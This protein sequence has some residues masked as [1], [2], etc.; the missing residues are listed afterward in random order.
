MEI[1]QPTP[2]LGGKVN[3]D[4]IPHPVAEGELATSFVY[5]NERT[6]YIKKR[7]KQVS[8]SSKA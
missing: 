7:I 3:K 4:V 8:F 2:L 1:A 6:Q 5:V